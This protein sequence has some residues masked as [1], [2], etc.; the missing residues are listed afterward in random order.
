M[1]IFKCLFLILIFKT[2]FA[3]LAPKFPPP[4]IFYFRQAN[5]ILLQPTF[6]PSISF[7]SQIIIRD[8]LKLII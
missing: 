1:L 3:V 2:K 7:V 6:F 4:V 5:W 8:T